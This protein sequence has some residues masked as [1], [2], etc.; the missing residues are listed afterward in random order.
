MKYVWALGLLLVIWGCSAKPACYNETN[1]N[2]IIRWGTFYA[3]SNTFDAYEMNSAAEIFSYTKADRSD[4][5]EL[6]QA[7][8]VRFCPAMRSIES[9]LLKTQ[10][11]ST[12]GDTLLF[13]ELNN[14]NT[15]LQ[16]RFAWNHSHINTG[17]KLCIAALDSLNALRNSIK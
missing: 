6:G 17:N 15:D 13:I 11:Y 12:P 2:Q 8:V 3:A 5:T 14:K 9:N 4:L 7:D 16:M 1:K 10:A